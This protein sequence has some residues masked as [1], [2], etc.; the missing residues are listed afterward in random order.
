MEGR[1]HVAASWDAVGRQTNLG[2]NPSSATDQRLNFVVFVAQACGL[3][4]PP[5]SLPSQG[6]RCLT[7]SP[8]ASRGRAKHAQAPRAA[9]SSSSQ[10]HLLWYLAASSG[11][12]ADASEGH[13]QALTRSAKADRCPG[14]FHHTRQSL[15]P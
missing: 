2:S 5:A 15:L 14:P 3:C 13:P 1:T 9:G 7:S 6:G 12:E 11:K 10:L 4:P 8:V